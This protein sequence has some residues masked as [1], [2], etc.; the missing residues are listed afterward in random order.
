MKRNRFFAALF[1]VVAACGG[2]SG[3]DGDKYVDELTAEEARQLCE[4][5]VEKQGGPM[6]K[7]CGGGVTITVRTVDEC[8]ASFQGEGAP[9]CQV[10]VAEDCLDALDGEPC[11]L[12]SKSE[13]ATFVAC[14]MS[15]GGL[16]GAN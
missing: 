3:V 14:G 16:M 15:S 6:T 10:S 12:F 2:G 13:C 11:N 7:M 8:V 1:V 4:W 9:H 5:G